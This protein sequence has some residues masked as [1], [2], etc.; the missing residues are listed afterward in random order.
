MVFLK[1]LRLRSNDFFM[2][3]IEL[4]TS[5][6]LSEPPKGIN[7]YLIALWHDEKG[8]WEEAHNIIQDIDN[9]NG[10]WIHAYLHRK[11][12]DKGN[13]QYWYNRAGKNFPKVNLE[14]EWEE[15]SSHFLNR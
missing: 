6:Q 14:E 12:G 9:S 4:K 15:I 5:L 8:N 10:A 7:T 11:E 13:A 2:T 3:L 1:S